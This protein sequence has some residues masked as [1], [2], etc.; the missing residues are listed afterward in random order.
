LPEDVIDYL[1]RVDGDPGRAVVKL[2]ATAGHPGVPDADAGIDDGPEI[3]EV[4]QA[5]GL[6]L[7]DPADVEGLPGVATIPFAGG[8]AFLA[9][10][11]GQT[12][13]DLELALVDAIEL[14]AD[15]DD[16]RRA[17]LVQWRRALRTWRTDPGL[18]FRERIILVIERVRSRAT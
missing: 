10:E 12:V 13:A 8:R 7:L 16:Q 14:G 15:G 11:P 9:L 2:C 3:A 4:G 18:R 5:R 6:I 1:R 17:G